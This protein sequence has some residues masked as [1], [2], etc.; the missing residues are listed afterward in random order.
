MSVEEIS[1]R[2]VRNTQILR[3]MFRVETEIEEVA[4]V[5]ATKIEKVRR[6]HDDREKEY[7]LTLSRMQNEIDFLK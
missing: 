3:E 6:V 1:F 2:K 4:R 5:T 7:G